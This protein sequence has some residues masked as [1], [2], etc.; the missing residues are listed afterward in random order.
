MGRCGLGLAAII[1]LCLAAFSAQP[2]RAGSF[3]TL[4]ANA[5]L[6]AASQPKPLLIAHF[7]KAQ[8]FYCYPRNYW[9]FYRPYT[10]APQNYPRCMPYFH[11]LGPEESLRGR[12]DR[13]LRFR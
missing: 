2:A 4:S 6:V 9:W 12:P 3:A 8:V 11:Y 7:R 13:V 5:D 10:T 1:A